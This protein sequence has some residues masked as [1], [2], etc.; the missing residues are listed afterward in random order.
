MENGR[1]VGL[2]LLAVG[3]V[4][5]YFGV[6]SEESFSSGL[7]ELFDGAPSFKTI[8][9]LA[10]GALLAAFGVAKLLRRSAT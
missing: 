1:F 10:S 6:K 8:L 7:A 2:V 3:G 5:I 4:L 9:L